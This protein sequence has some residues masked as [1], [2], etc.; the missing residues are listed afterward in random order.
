MQDIGG[1]RAV[2]GESDD[3]FN[4]AA[5]FAASR[6]R[7]ELVR[8]SNYITHP[9]PSGYRSLHLVYAYNSD[10]TPRWQDL[11]VE[12]QIR[13]ELQHQWA[14]AVETVGT[15]IGD[16]L[17]SNVGD[18]NWLRF[19]A[20]MSTAISQREGTPEVP[21]T[22][23]NHRELIAGIEDCDRILGISERLAAFQTLT[24][25]LQNLRRISDHWVVPKSPT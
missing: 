19:F 1:C 12:V 8:Y 16:D 15:F 18:P 13:S 23:T 24:R 22:P 17:K 6:I 9:R 2:V 20:L 25:Q 3:A 4:L 5:D 14:T 21:N 10:R 7:H 11:K